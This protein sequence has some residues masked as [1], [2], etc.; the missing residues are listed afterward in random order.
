MIKVVDLAKDLGR[1][2]VTLSTWILELGIQVEVGEYNIHY[3]TEEDADRLRERNLKPKTG[4]NKTGFSGSSADV[5]YH[6]RK[7]I[8]TRISYGGFR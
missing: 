1:V 3:I 6:W 4:G 8:P 7:G 2:R 5:N